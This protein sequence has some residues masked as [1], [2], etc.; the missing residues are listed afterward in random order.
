MAVNVYRHLADFSLLGFI[1]LEIGIACNCKKEMK[2][3]I[4]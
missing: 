2:V 3:N 4:S 1:T